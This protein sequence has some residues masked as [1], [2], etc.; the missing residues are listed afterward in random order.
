VSARIGFDIGGTFTDLVLEDGSRTCIHKVLTTPRRPAEGALRGLDELVAMAAA[1]W[2]EVE[3]VVHGTTLVTNAVIERAGAPTG[4]ITTRGFR[5]V[6]AMG[7]QQRYD[8]YDLRLR[9][10]EA[11]VPRRRRLEVDERTLASGRVLRPVDLGQVRDAAARLAGEGVGAIAVCFLHAYRNPENERAAVEEIRAAVP[12]LHAVASFEVAPVIRE[13]ERTVTTAACAFAQPI[14]AG[15]LEELEAALR[16]R[17]F[18][19]RLLLMQ[20]NGGTASARHVAQVPIRLLESGPAGGVRAAARTALGRGDRDLISFDMGGT[21]A[22]ACL[23]ESSEPQLLAELEVA[24]VD[25]F[26]AGSGLPLHTSSV[27][28]IEIGAGGGSVA[29]V[30]RLGLLRVGPESAGADPGPACY[31]LGGSKPTVTD[32]NLVLGY[33]GE[34]SFL[35]GR[36]RLDRAAAE[37]AVGALGRRLGLDVTQTAWGIH[38]LVNEN[39]AAAARV[40]VI[41]RGHDPR[42]YVMLGFGGAGP[43]H[44]AGIGRLVGLR[45]VVIPGGAGATSAMGFL[46][47][48]ALQ[49][50]A[51]SLPAV[52]G[53]VDWAEVEALYA[54]MEADVAAGLAE[55]GVPATAA[56]FQRSAD[57]RLLGQV[58]EL[59]VPVERLADDALEAAF[60]TAYRERFTLLP[61][62]LPVQVLTWRVEAAGPSAELAASQV[63]AAEG[64]PARKGARRVYFPGSGYVECHVYERHRLEPGG[65]LPG[66]AIVEEAEATTL[67]GPGDRF[68]V[69]ERGNLVIDLAEEVSRG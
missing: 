30:D 48:P 7:R 12:T 2:P 24:R 38:R 66:P 51:T 68:H 9:F 23:V 40:H 63:G 37:Q 21:T 27:D 57:M 11:L 69:D 45:Q 50:A 14:A 52:L 26:T 55:I 44:A 36:M 20:S 31:G 62:G 28:L 1:T 15:Y 5:D 43:A 19:G 56:R 46:V 41:G 47:S 33:L 64:G 17:G 16:A 18:A 6:L 10:P 13:Y 53:R 4:L 32:A 54:R 49:D 60:A 67:V 35:G 39:M 61:S 29:A 3:E 42:R 59:R 34:D 22:K 8:A 58:H 25:R 65:R